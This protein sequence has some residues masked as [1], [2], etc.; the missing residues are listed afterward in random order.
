MGI[1]QNFLRKQ[2][3]HNS[4][5]SKSHLGSVLSRANCRYSISEINKRRRLLLRQ[6]STAGW[7]VPTQDWAG[8]CPQNSRC[9]DL[10]PFICKEHARALLFCLFFFFSLNGKLFGIYCQF[11][12]FL[13]K[14]GCMSI[15]LARRYHTDKFVDSSGRRCHCSSNHSKLHQWKFSLL[16]MANWSK[17]SQTGRHEHICKNLWSLVYC[18]PLHTC[19]FTALSMSWLW[20]VT[21]DVFLIINCPGAQEMILRIKDQPSTSGRVNPM[22]VEGDNWLKCIEA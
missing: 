8:G 9:Q 20:A 14:G 10:C 12:G 4:T 21:H 15:L 22:F 17:A 7:W 1:K 13:S 18:I 2:N 5:F 11:P 19:P 16:L 3:T 6:T